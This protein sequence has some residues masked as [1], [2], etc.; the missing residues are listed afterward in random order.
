MNICQAI[1]PEDQKFAFPRN[2]TH[3]VTDYWD[4]NTFSFCTREWESLA[5]AR[6]DHPVSCHSAFACA[7]LSA[8][9]SF[10]F[11]MSSKLGKV[12]QRP[13]LAPSEH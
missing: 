4:M 2:L 8:W 9:N 7:V 13:V 11:Y 12:P 5:E 3:R 10:C 1:R 6:V